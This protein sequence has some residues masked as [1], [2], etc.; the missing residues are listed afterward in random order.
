MDSS[1][2]V[3][4]ATW[5]P[6]RGVWETN[7]GSMLCEHLVPFLETF[8]T[9][10]MTRSGRLSRL[11]QPER[12]TGGNASSYLP[13]PTAQLN[14][15]APWKPGVQW[16]LQSRASR[17]LEG[18]VTGNTPLL[19][20]PDSQH[21]RKDSRTSPLLPGAIEDLTTSTST[22]RESS[23]KLLP[24][25]A[26]NDSHN[27]PEN[28]LRKKPWPQPGHEPADHR[29]E[30]ADR[31]GRAAADAVGQRWHG[32]SFIALRCETLREAAWRLGERLDA[33]DADADGWRREIRAELN[34]EPDQYPADGR[35]LGQYADGRGQ[36]AADAPSGHGMSDSMD[37][38]RERLEGGARSRS[39][40]EEATA[41]MPTPNARDWKGSPSKTWSGQASLPRTTA[42]LQQ[43][44]GQYSAGIARWESVLDRPAPRPAE[45]GPHGGMRLSPRFVEWMMG[46]PPGWVTDVPGLSRTEQLKALGNGVVPQQCALAVSRLLDVLAGNRNQQLDAGRTSA[47][48]DSAGDGR[49]AP[50]S[51]PAARRARAGTRRWRLPESA[52]NCDR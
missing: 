29:G 48:S 37:S 25:P 35:P 38:A 5:N 19:P 51:G 2:P 39:T 11:P 15:P 26:A 42:E 50:E 22:G 41:M 30:R 7:Q 20:T 21:G 32:R 12:R 1:Q 8:P 46:L 24:T 23:S 3:P 52:G 40:L 9:S 47:P 17:N 31:D 45:P 43:N 36:P 4:T 14:A 6:A 16:W 49:P 13:T 34:R 28:H 44:W 18:L 33:A 10:G 27:S